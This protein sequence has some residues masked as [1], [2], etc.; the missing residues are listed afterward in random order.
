MKVGAID[1]GNVQKRR[2]VNQRNFNELKAVL[3]MFASV[4]LLLLLLFAVVFAGAT[5]TSG[6]T[7]LASV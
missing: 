3:S 2:P 7:L 6:G 4:V 5:Q 1:G